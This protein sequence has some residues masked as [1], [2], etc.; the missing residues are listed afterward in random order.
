[1]Q[2]G[3]PALAVLL[4]SLA[5]CATRAPDASPPPAPASQWQAQLPHDGN[6]RALADWWQRFDDPLLA[7]LI[8]SAQANSPTL[9]QALARVGQAR[10]A[11]RAAEA[12]RGPSVSATAQGTRSKGPTT[13]NIAVTQASAGVDAQWELDLFGGL[14]HGAAAARAR[15]EQARLAWHDARVSLAADVAQTYTSLRAC[16]ALAAVYQQEV[17]SQQK[18]VELTREKLRV[19]FDT[20]ANAALADAA[21]AQ[22]RERL[23]GTQAD[24]DSTVKAL[25]LLT[26]LPEPELRERIAPR[27]AALPHPAP[28]ALAELPAQVLAQRPDIA[29]AERELVAAA[30][31]VGVADAQR[32]PHLTIAGNVGW[33]LTRSFGASSDGPA[34]GFGPTLV[35][36][37]F[38]GGALNAQLD[39]ARERYNEARAGMDL[40]LRGAVREVED[41]L[42]RLDGASRRERDAGIAAQGFRAYFD[43]AQTR[44]QLGAGSLFE[45]EEAR[46]SALAAE[47]GLIGV[48]REQAAAWISLYRAV[49]GGWDQTL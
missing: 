45:M 22:S 15:A 9:A 7:P 11:L 18:S 10:A 12:A 5:A 37:V 27:R 49:G 6:P 24:C 1:M 47:A 30:A 28:L 38:N 46:R 29:A 23:L 16:E 8:D 21:A 32:Y 3:T 39:A 36:P 20:P 17:G 26:A 40:R 33:G 19:G 31:E 14:G 2:P 41:A 13:S 44:W 42:V 43:A 25:V 4:L 34:W 48:Q 35:L